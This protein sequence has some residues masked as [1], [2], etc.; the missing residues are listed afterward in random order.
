[1][2]ITINGCLGHSY[3][4]TNIIA[5]PEQ[6]R[7]TASESEEISEDSF[8][9]IGSVHKINKAIYGQEIMMQ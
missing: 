4:G 1:M 8:S 2:F 5:I 3:L 7:K 9:V 6:F